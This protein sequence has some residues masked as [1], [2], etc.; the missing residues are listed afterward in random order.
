MPMQKV[1]ME[2]AFAFSMWKAWW[3]HFNTMHGTQFPFYFFFC[4]ID[5]KLYKFVWFLAIMWIVCESYMHKG[6]EGEN[7]KA[8]VN[9]RI[10]NIRILIFHEFFLSWA[11]Y[12]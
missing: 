6:Q 8:C 3:S 7:E 12:V 1:R 4:L 9:H 5:H 10:K 2:N 11:S